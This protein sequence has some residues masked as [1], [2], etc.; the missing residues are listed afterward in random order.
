MSKILSFIAIIFALIA[1][2]SFIISA[3]DKLDIIKGL[4]LVAD[5]MI[6]EYNMENI[7]RYNND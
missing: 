1:I 6:I 2:F 7:R 4:F 3:H 5:G